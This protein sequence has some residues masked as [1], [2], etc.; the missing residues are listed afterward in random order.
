MSFPIDPTSPPVRVL[1]PFVDDVQIRLVGTTI[2]VT[3]ALDVLREVFTVS[4]LSELERARG[5]HVRL[6]ATINRRVPYT[7][8]LK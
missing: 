7:G 6:Y 4:G 2:D 3:A 5:R 1:R 8:G